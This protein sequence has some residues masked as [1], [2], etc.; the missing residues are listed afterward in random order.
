MPLVVPSGQYLQ[1]SGAEMVTKRT[2]R[3]GQLRIT[4][5]STASSSER[6]PE[7]GQGAPETGEGDGPG[8]RMHDP[9]KGRGYRRQTFAEEATFR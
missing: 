4:E 8:V 6:A 7:A 5:R 1:G 9:S 3:V 2:Y